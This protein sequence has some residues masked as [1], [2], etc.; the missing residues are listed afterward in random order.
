MV[1]AKCKSQKKRF[2]FESDAKA[3]AEK[4]KSL[5]GKTQKPY[6]CPHCKNWH[7]TTQQYN[8]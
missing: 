8:K 1:I 4:V 7:L 6:L 3:F 5:L 2:L